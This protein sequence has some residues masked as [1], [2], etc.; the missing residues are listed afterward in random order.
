M[1]LLLCL[2]LRPVREAEPWI[3]QKEA[4]KSPARALHDANAKQQAAL[5][6]K[7]A[8]EKAVVDAKASLHKMLDD[9][10]AVA[11]SIPGLQLA[12]EKAAKS[13]TA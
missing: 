13:G 1:S 6:K 2:S 4:E 8:A 10:R 3:K 7:V 9:M 5:K 11:D 12:A